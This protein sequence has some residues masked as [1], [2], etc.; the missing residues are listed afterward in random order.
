MNLTLL[1]DEFA[2]CQLPADAPI[3]VWATGPSAFLSITRT[4]EELSITCPAAFVPAD[5]K[6]EGPWR[7]FK[8]AGPLDFAL[9]GVLASLAAPLAQAGISIFAVATYRTDYVLVKATQ[10]DAA[11]RVLQTAGHFV[12]PG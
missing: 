9:T 7:A 10:V 8:V 11:T 2:V 3:P 4:S 12:Q 5:V 6:Q 1:P